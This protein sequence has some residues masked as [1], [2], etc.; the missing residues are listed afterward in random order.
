[1]AEEPKEQKV[2]KDFWR[3]ALEDNLDDIRERLLEA[4]A[5]TK[6]VWVSCTHCKH[7]NKVEIP[8][9]RARTDAA[10]ALH[11]LAGE[12]PKAGTEGGSSGAGFI[13]KRVLIA[14]DGAEIPLAAVGMK[15]LEEGD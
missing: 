3:H 11:E 7:R 15:P 13:L 1:M 9:H 6:E 14:P 8:D 4:S 2:V 12:R 5:A 10:R